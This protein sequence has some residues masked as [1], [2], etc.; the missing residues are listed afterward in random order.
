MAADHPV[1]PGGSHVCGRRIMSAS[2]PARDGRDRP[3]AP[4]QVRS[5]RFEPVDWSMKGL[6]NLLLFLA[7]LVLACGESGPTESATPVP[8]SVSITPG[9]V[10]LAALGETVHLTATVLD[11][12]GQAMQGV[13]LVWA[14]SDGSVATVD[15]A[16]VVTAVWNGSTTVTAA[17][18]GGGASGRARVTVAQQAREIRVSPDQEMFRALADTLRLSARV[19]D[20]NG[21]LVESADFNWFSSDESV[22]T[23]DPTGLVTSAGNGS[24]S[25]TVSSGPASGNADFVVAQ[26]PVE[27]QLTSDADTLRAFGDTLRMRVAGTDANGHPVEN[28]G[29]GFTWSSG[30]RTVATVDAGGLVTA[31]GNGRAT[32]TASR[33]GFALDATVTVQQVAAEVRLSSMA[34]TLRAI[35]DTLR[36]AAEA[37]DRNGHAVQNAEFAWSS[38]DE[39]IATVDGMGLVTA[40]GNGRANVMAASGPASATAGIAV[41]QLATTIQVS[42]AADTLQWLG[43]TLRLSAE[44]LDANRY[45]VERTAFTWSSSDELIATVDPAGLVTAE[46]VGSVE[47]TAASGDAGITGTATL[48]VEAL[49]AR[50]ALIAL[51]NATGGPNWI[52]NE[53]WLT[54]E[55]L[56]NW[57]GVGTSHV[58]H[59]KVTHLRLRENG[60]AGP[61]PPELGNLADLE[62]LDLQKNDLTGPIPS[63]LGALGNLQR[64]DLYKNGLSGPIPPELEN[65]RS[66]E[67]LDL[68]LNDMSGLIPPELG[69]LTK[70][71]ALDLTWNDLSGSIPLELGNLTNLRELDL[72]LNDLSGP[73]PPVLGS[74]TSLR[75]LLLAVN[76]LSG[77][78][79]PE[80]GDLTHL[81]DLALNSNTLTGAIPPEIGRLVNLET[82]SLSQ[83]AFTGPIPRELGSLTKLKEIFLHHAE[84]TGPIPIEL[85]QLAALRVLRLDGN[86]LTGS[87]PAEL[88]SLGSLRALY[89]DGN[90]LTGSIPPQLGALASL[91]DLRLSDNELTGPIPLE[92]ARL[93][94]LKQLF[95]DNNSGLTGAIPQGFVDFDLETFWWQD[96]QLC[97]PPNDA[98]QT[99]L[100]SIQHHVGGATCAP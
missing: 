8:S 36:L 55:P 59:D 83:N 53:N 28:A 33:G 25:V 54:R 65:L 43:D 17:V 98:F 32:V 85:A 29:E 66:L 7:A 96:T 86:R 2:F 71:E 100:A 84:L 34:D 74:L 92:L 19:F 95:F 77:P 75:R 1:A 72:A 62:E 13:T 24:A 68:S 70:L 22:V 47:I 89:L 97:A 87:I 31:V 44:A 91:G 69:N 88:A 81:R 30:D 27:V 21:H 64:L 58:D 61:I 42:P 18:Q 40:V 57:H 38:S 12:G 76:Q 63:E 26:E 46:G 49:P 80:L 3:L 14:S 73:I 45:A 78:I 93:T 99:W 82:F 5:Q 23:V 52:N 15:A 20:A 94:N 67:S 39:S 9:S 51:Y 50:D 79:P 56:R 6:R 90:S 10:T 48:V 35:A 11:Q 60:L 4:L 16:G 41:A 37:L